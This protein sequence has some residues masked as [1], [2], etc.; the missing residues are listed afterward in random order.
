VLSAAA[1]TSLREL[2]RHR[3]RTG[4]SVVTLA[5]AVA[6]V[7][8]LAL[9]TL[10]DR[11]MQAEVRAGRLADA[12]IDV[13]PVELTEEQLDGLAAIPNVAAVEPRTG[14]ST[15]ILVGE[16]RAPAVIIGVR[17]FADQR[18]DVVRVDSGQL[19]ATGQ[20]LADVQNDNADVHPGD[21][22]DTVTVLA[23]NGRAVELVLTGRGRSLP[24][25]ELVQDERVA[26]FYTDVATVADLTGEPGISTLAIRFDDTEPAA[27]DAA[28]DEIRSVLATVPGYRG[29]TDLPEVR[30][31][32]DWPGKAETETFGQFVAVITVLAL[33]SAVVLVSN[34]MST[35]VAEQ[36]REIA[37]MRAIGARRRQV[38]AIFVRTAL[39]LGALGAAVGA[40]LGSVVAA[41][42]AAY[43]GH[44]FWAVDIGF[45][46]S[47]SVLL[48]SVVVGLL[49]PVLAA[50]PAVRR[51][52]R[53]DLAPAL[54]ASG[55]ALGG[56]GATD[57]ILR[58]VGFLPRVAQIGLRNVGRRRRRSIAT[59]AIVALAVANLLAVMALTTAVTDAVESAWGDHLEDVQV[60]TS[61]RELF[62]D[63]AFAAVA[64][65]PGVA[66]VEP[67]LKNTVALDGREAF[68]WGVEQDPLFRY[69]LDG[70][71]WFTA[72]ES[73]AGEPVAVIERNLAE[74]VGVDVGDPITVTTAGGSA[75]FRIVGRAT[76]Q[77]E[78]GTAIYVPVATVREL[79]GVTDGATS[80]LVQATSPDA[81]VVD[82]TTAAVEDRLTAL[83]YEVGTE[84][85]Y[86]AERDEVAENRSVTTAIAVLGFLIVGMSMVGLANATTTNILER[87]RE[88][89]VLRSI[90][91]RA[92]DV[93]RIFT[94]EGL[95]LALAG[96]LVGIPLGYALT[97]LLVR[98][99]WEFAEV[100]IPVRFPLS[101]LPIALVG[102]VV[103]GLLVLALPVRRAVRLR[104]GEALRY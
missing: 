72:D 3:A 61:G 48:L 47:V 32:G 59:V 31:P 86:I 11:G 54:E 8:F 88:I 81:D 100:R 17:D 7:S 41:W 73:E 34:T 12:S 44:Q 13:R 52:L 4:F 35:L 45:S 97:R 64:S 37:V 85:R 93:R 78:D 103:L 104:P 87:T 96:W 49:A 30:A 5:L 33:L 51:G 69:R 6:S 56:A 68:M 65:T 23:P 58:R 84:V 83:G 92:R 101:S 70:G 67:V 15:R 50:L 75:T 99:V 53:T 63:A 26:V 74:M 80:Y 40:A 28:V 21:A 98:L 90:G 25:G 91:A 57:G 66:D 46:V 55:S 22:G 27:V 24:G 76:N 14:V 79:L 9:P 42:L 19:P 20:L 89:G 94:T 95:A 77:Q 1:R 10:I 39:L 38:A 36:T 16:R 60:W 29:L 18:V 71:R 43:F 2:S 62:D 82:R 102:T